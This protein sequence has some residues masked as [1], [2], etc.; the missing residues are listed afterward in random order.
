MSGRP[1]RPR[2]AERTAAPSLMDSAEYAELYALVVLAGSPA[3]VAAAAARYEAAARDLRRRCAVEMR[4]AGATWAEVGHALGVS[5]QG[6]A[7]LCQPP[8]ASR[9]YR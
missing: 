9:S 6:A 1:T 2:G 4:A 7:K 5:L 3:E 8:R